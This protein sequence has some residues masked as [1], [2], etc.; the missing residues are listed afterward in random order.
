MINQNKEKFKAE[1]KKALQEEPELLHIM[2][3]LDNQARLVGGCVRDF[4]LYEK[5]VYDIDIATTYSPD[6][7]QKRL[8]NFYKV[9]PTGLKHGTVTV[10][11]KYKY[12][13]TT[14]RKDKETDGRHAKVEFSESWEED[15]NRRDFTINGLY[16]D[17]DGNLY[18]Y[19]D[20]LT[21]LS[22]LFVKFIAD[23]FERIHEDYLRI[24]RFYRFLA[25]FGNYDKASLEACVNLRSNLKKI[26]GERITQEWF[27]IAEGKCFFEIL[28][29][30]DLVLQEIGLDIQKFA[31]YKNYQKLSKLGLSAITIDWD[32]SRLVLS[33]HEKQYIKNL[34]MLKIE[35][36]S[37]AIIYAKKYGLD[38]VQDKMLIE[39]RF[40]EI[41]DLP[42]MPLS[43]LDLLDLHYSGKEL[44]EIKEEL[45]KIW[46][47]NLGLLKK[48]DLIAVAKSR[49]KK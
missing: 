32:R 1:F 26:S 49:V 47:D 34:Q 15:S 28:P 27:K 19:H 31:N 46:V 9:I 5:L 40:F 33:N 41:V 8:E 14:L 43:G 20:G 17:V 35:N 30:V 18:D 13:I 23:P 44:G 12:E 45:Y 16:A 29:L 2:E 36:R 39:D 11:G 4:I 10:V 7:V 48:E 21:D 37:D 42:E 3:L 25:R 6:E 24:L 22:N 38:F